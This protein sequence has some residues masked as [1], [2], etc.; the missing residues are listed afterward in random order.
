MAN[1]TPL[2]PPMVKSIRKAMAKSIAVR[3]WSDPPHMVA[4]QLNTFTPV[5]TAI[6][7]LVA[8]KKALNVLPNP[9]ANMWCAHTPNER[10]MMATDEAATN[11]YP[12]MGFREN[13]GMTSEMIPKAGNARI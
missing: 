9:T 10:S 11:S 1:N 3:S 8:A 6:N 12:N 2:S 4:V 13:T 7:I 5:G